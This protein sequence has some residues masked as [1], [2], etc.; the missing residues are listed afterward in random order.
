MS[1]ASQGVKRY[2][3]VSFSLQV[4]V[5]QA[6]YPPLSILDVNIQEPSH[7]PAQ[8]Y[9]PVVLQSTPVSPPAA[10]MAMISDEEILRKKKKYTAPDCNDTRVEKV[11]YYHFRV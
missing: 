7:H 8:M 6:L 5:S 9:R 3:L 2:A 10:H 1:P 11:T 4:S